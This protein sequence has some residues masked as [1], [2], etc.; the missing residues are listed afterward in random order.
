MHLISLY[1]L[2]SSLRRQGSDPI[3]YIFRYASYFFSFSSKRPKKNETEEDK[4]TKLVR[5]A[6]ARAQFFAFVATLLIGK[7]KI[8]CIMFT[9]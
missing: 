6:G 4:M 5:D 9:Y 1:F 7:G 2:K 8:L 3:G